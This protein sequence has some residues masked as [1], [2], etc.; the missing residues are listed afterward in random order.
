MYVGSSLRANRTSSASATT[1]VVAQCAAA[2]S[3]CLGCSG[4]GSK[5][6][7]Y[8][9]SPSG[10]ESSR[11]RSSECGLTAR[12]LPTAAICAAIGAPCRSLTVPRARS[13]G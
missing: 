3:S 12:C 8:S 9:I 4:S 7:A 5:G 2:L 6:W 11:G 10:G 1:S 13:R